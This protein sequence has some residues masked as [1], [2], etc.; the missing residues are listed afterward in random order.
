MGANI[1]RRAPA[2]GDADVQDL[3]DSLRRVVQGLRESSRQTER[4][5]GL[6]AAQFFVLRG[7]AA[8]DG[9]SINA[10]AAKTFTH[11][12]SVSAVVS[13][14]VGRRLV[15]RRPD[16]QDRRRRQLALTRAGHRAL[17]AAP[18]SGHERLIAAALTMPPATRRTA[19]RALANLADAMV[20]DR[21]P[22]MFF[23]ERGRS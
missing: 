3:L 19:A 15:E 20:V 5:T 12:S 16:P 21:R 14:L 4:R 1:S 18:A 10:L 2:R 8:D 22:A 6:T 13:R 23:E 17:R 7:L 11:Q 9:L